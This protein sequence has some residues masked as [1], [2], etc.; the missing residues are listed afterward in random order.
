MPPSRLRRL[1]RS[2]PD[3]A[4]QAQLLRL[5]PVL[6][7]AAFA[8]VWIFV[9]GP[10]GALA[11]AVGATIAW[12]VL[13]RAESPALRAGGRSSS[14]T[15]R[16][17][18]TCSAACL[19][20][21]AATSSALETV[22]HALPGAVAD[23]LLLV[24]HRLA[25]GVDPVSVWH[26]LARHPQLRPL[27]RSLERA[28]V[29]GA[30]VCGAVEALASEL[31]AQARARTDA[32]AR[33]RRGPGRGP[34]RRVLPACLRAARCGADGRRS[35]L[36]DAAVLGRAAGLPADPPPT[37][38]ADPPPST[39]RPRRRLSTG[40]RQP[41]EAS[42][43]SAD[44]RRPPQEPPGGSGPGPTQGGNMTTTKLAAARDELG[45]PRRS[46]PCARARVSASPECCSAS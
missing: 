27:G 7:S 26:D 12:R 44:R 20:A 33:S 41:L 31:A 45:P 13:G 32:L 36:R 46:T 42:S 22:G 28:H 39:A 16:P 5:R 43:R 3:A 11:G 37:T 29:S 18:S 38:A 4:E 2:R 17:R 6:V 21:G 1:R 25:L 24:R 40:R 23:E 34:A 30:S 35:L 9:G 10:V 14:A 8:G 19:A 15:C